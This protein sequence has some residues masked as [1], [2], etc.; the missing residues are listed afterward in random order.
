MHVN[1]EKKH[2][3]KN[4]EKFDKLYLSSEYISNIL[5]KSNTVKKDI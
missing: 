5:I 2:K 3:K 4:K 1:I